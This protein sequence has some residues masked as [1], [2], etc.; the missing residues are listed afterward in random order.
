MPQLLRRLARCEALIIDDIGYVQHSRQEMELLFHLLSQRYERGSVLITSNLA[1]SQWERQ[2][3]G[4][5]DHG[6]GH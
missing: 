3:A 2:I 4:P 6:G 1:F 5:H